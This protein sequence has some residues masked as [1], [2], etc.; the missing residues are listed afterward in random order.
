MTRLLNHMATILADSDAELDDVKNLLLRIDEQKDE[1]LHVM[2]KLENIYRKSKDNVND[3]K[4]ID[5]AEILVDQVEKET[6]SVVYS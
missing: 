1:T 4:V 6:S 5:E 2:D 3:G